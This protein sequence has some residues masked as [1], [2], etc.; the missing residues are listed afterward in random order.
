MFNESVCAVIVTYN[1]KTLLLECLESLRKQTR[2][3]Q[4]IYLIDNA[5]KDGTPELLLEKGYITEPP[6]KELNEPWEKEFTIQNLTDGS[7]IRFHYV[8]M[9]ENTGGAGGFYEGVKRGYEKGYDW[10]WLM[11][12]DAEPKEDALEEAAK[13]FHIDCVAVANL[14]LDRT[15]QILRYSRGYLDCS[16]SPGVIVKPLSPDSYEGKETIEIDFASFVGLIV[17]KEGIRKAG[18]PNKYFYIYFDDVEYCLRL[19]TFGKILLITKSLI[20]HENSDGTKIAKYKRIG[21][22]IIRIEDSSY[23]WRNYYS[24]RNMINL[25]AN[26]NLCNSKKVMLLTQFL[27]YT[28]KAV[29]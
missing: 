28:A 19:K 4:G 23:C 15:Y 1:R 11:D 25:K 12:D 27:L 5:S 29:L 21:K 20:F 10:L 8:R 6:P 9:H 3:L 2:P 22:F 17:K 16:I 18:Y 7:T 24:L 13:Y 14:L 26:Y